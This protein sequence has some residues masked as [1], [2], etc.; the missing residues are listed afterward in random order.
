MQQFDYNPASDATKPLFSSATYW[1]I[2]FY[3]R[4]MQRP[5]FRKLTA[6]TTYELFVN[7]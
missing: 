2:F 7:S 4:R 3:F 5:G 6:K 1:A